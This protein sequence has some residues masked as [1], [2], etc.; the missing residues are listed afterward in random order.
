[1]PPVVTAGPL[2]YPVELTRDGPYLAGTGAARPL[3]LVVNAAAD[4]L[5]G[6]DFAERVAAGLDAD[7]P[8]DFALRPRGGYDLSELRAA[9]RALAGSDPGDDALLVG[10][11]YE[12]ELLLVPPQVLLEL[13]ERLRELRS[14]WRA[15]SVDTAELERRAH[16]VDRLELTGTAEGVAR[17]AIKRR[18]LLDDLEAAGILAPGAG[19]LWSERLDRE[20]RE[21]LVGYLWAGE[22]MNAYRASEQRARLVGDRGAEVSLDW[23]RLGSPVPEGADPLAWTA[24]W[25]AALATTGVGDEAAGFY[26]SHED[27]G[28]YRV[29]WRRERAGPALLRAEPVT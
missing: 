22:R 6:P 13:L 10:T 15:A 25:E 5:V 11:R 29:E 23:F 24:R 9:W 19:R 12:R 8:A 1:V 28:W 26:L 16:E 2:E 17:A 3:A 20:G 27:L 18:L 14:E 7:G 21:R 4:G